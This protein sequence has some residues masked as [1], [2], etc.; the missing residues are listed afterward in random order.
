MTVRFARVSSCSGLFDRLVYFW[1]EWG[2]IG[3]GYRLAN[4]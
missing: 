1:V 4:V 2:D 3:A